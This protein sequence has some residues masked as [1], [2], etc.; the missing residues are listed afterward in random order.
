MNV[1]SNVG[2]FARFAAL[3][4]CGWRISGKHAGVAEGANGQV[5]EAAKCGEGTGAELDAGQRFLD[6]SGF[7]QKY[8]TQGQVAYRWYNYIMYFFSGIKGELQW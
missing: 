8:I 4:H 2:R 7:D 3:G 5:P 1:M 6:E